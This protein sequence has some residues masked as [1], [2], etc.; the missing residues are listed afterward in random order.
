MLLNQ[1]LNEEA[2]ANLS[3]VGT[4]P[5]PSTGAK[6]HSTAILTPSQPLQFYRMPADL[7]WVILFFQCV[8]LL[9]VTLWLVQTMQLGKSHLERNC[10]EDPSASQLEDAIKNA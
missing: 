8:P 6:F 4:L 7:T 5:V 9:P 1:R 2:L 10:T 3:T